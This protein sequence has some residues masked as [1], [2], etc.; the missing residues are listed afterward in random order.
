MSP[1]L[2][3]LAPWLVGFVAGLAFGLLSRI[4]GD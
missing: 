4:L 3:A 2:V 1:E